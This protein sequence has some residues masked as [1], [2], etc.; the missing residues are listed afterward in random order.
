[1][2]RTHPSRRTCANAA[3]THN[4]RPRIRFSDDKAEIDFIDLNA[5][6]IRRVFV[7][8]KPV[9]GWIGGLPVSSDGKLPIFPHVDEFSSDLMTIENWK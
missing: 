2:P 9:C 8:D 1:V 3:I 7:P 5:Q 4:I 6:K